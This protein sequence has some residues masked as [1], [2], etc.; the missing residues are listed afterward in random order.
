M[1]E[2]GTVF[3]ALTKEKSTYTTDTSCLEDNSML[4][5]NDKNNYSKINCCNE[6]KKTFQISAGSSTTSQVVCIN[7]P[8]SS[9]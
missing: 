3:N 6:T 9:A 1:S 8:T 7:K 5:L 2:L 4:K